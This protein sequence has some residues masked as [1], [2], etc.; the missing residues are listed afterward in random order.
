VVVGVTIVVAP[1]VTTLGT[2]P[3]PWMML[4]RP[5]A[6][7]TVEMGAWMV[8]LMVVIHV[9]NLVDSTENEFEA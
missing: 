1:V 3:V 9:M 4:R 8:L 5:Y 6:L 7:V 2:A